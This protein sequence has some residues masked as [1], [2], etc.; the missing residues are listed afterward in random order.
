MIPRCLYYYVVI[1]SK[2]SLRCEGRVPAVR[3][4]LS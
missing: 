2:H 1:P 4:G 3:S